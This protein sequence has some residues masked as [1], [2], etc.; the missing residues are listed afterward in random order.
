MPNACPQVPSNKTL[1]LM[2][3]K[4]IPSAYNQRQVLRKTWLNQE[5]WTKLDIVIHTIFLMGTQLDPFGQ[6]IDLDHREFN[7]KG[8]FIIFFRIFEFLISLEKVKFSSPI[9]ASSL[10]MEKS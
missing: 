2:A 6:H 3:I 7:A 1:V 9:N 5:Y 10:N 4:T 8:S